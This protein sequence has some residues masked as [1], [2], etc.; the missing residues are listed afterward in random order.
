MQITSLTL[1]GFK[2]FEI[3]TQINFKEKSDHLLSNK[4]S[5]QKYYLFEV[6]LGV[7]FGLTSEE[8]INFRDLDSSVQTFTGMLT[9]EF[10]DRTMLIERDFETDFVACLISTPKEV[11][12]FYQGKDFILDGSP[13]PYLKVLD[14]FLSITEKDI[15]LEICYDADAND[16]KNLFG[17]LN[18][19]Y[20][21]LAP[22]LI[23]K[24]STALIQP[25][26]LNNEILTSFSSEAPV[27]EQIKFLKNKRTFLT[28]MMI[29]DSRINEIN[30]DLEQLQSLI[31]S[32]QSKSKYKN[33]LS[34]ELKQRF[35]D[36]Y[37]ENALELR[38]DILLW[39]SLKQKKIEKEIELENTN[40]RI[41][42]VKR[43]I[44]S[45][46]AAYEKVPDTF[47]SDF[48]R[49]GKL[50]SELS[51][52][53]RNV[54]ESEQKLKSG[55]NKLKRKRQ[56]RWLLLLAAPVI[57]FLAS[58]FIFG[59]FWLLIIPETVIVILA[60]LLYFGHVNESIRAEIFHINEEKRLIEM[61]IQ[62]IESE[63]NHIFVHNPLF[64]DE[65]YLIIH[66]DRFKKFSKY[67]TEL[68]ELKKKEAAIYG[69][70]HSDRLTKQLRD[71]EDKY[72]E[73]I[74]IDRH[75]IEEYLDRFVEAQ[76]E[77]Q[78]QEN[79]KFPGVEVVSSIK[80]K[81]LVTLSN[82]KSFREKVCEDLHLE[83]GTTE[84]EIGNISRMIRKLESSFK[85]QQI[86]P[87][88][89]SDIV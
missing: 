9:I 25:D 72:S 59:P 1:S 58:L 7:L 8:K 13:R 19:L 79:S 31:N 75:D 15:I 74:N 85:D 82:L 87:A 35:P 22:Q 81:Y 51:E 27:D 14:E 40:T 69:E 56:K 39:K 57:T 32:I 12:P 48:D 37:E 49:F 55:E 17:L 24:D 18:T 2:Y 6:I 26:K 44:Q 65:E 77:A 60:V 54:N 71:Y 20:M 52:K 28:D 83:T 63:I 10:S 11:R 3:N 70:L 41:K 67:Q 36:I 16:P 89:I 88:K 61:H 30:Y 42:Q 46:Y 4:D 86:D 43:L 66:L 53:R 50:K 29:I 84:V 80:R 73:K 76:R 33:P 21:L 68:F 45:D 5:E 78:R 34:H 64:K 23:I 47:E 62:E 38:A